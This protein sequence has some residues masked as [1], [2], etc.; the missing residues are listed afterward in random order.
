MT[1]RQSIIEYVIAP[2]LRFPDDYDLDAIFEDC[3]AWN[4][5]EYIQVDDIEAVA[6]YALRVEYL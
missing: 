5:I 3:F 2:A 1:Y 6:D 4:G